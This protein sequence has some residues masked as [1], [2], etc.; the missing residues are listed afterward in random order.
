MLD[1]ECGFRKGPVVIGPD[2]MEEIPPVPGVAPGRGVGGGDVPPPSLLRSFRVIWGRDWASSVAS[3]E[4]ALVSH[5]ARQ[6]ATNRKH[7]GS[8]TLSVFLFSRSSAPLLDTFEQ[9][10]LDPLP[11]PLPL[12]LDPFS[13]FFVRRLYAIESM[14]LL[15]DHRCEK[16]RSFEGDGVQAQLVCG[17]SVGTGGQMVRKQIQLLDSLRIVSPGVVMYA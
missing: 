11:A 8:C 4:A 6:R 10:L 9:P 2:D 14:F 16:R 13:L 7:T 5:P 15:Q 3:I 17:Y 12:I 1:R